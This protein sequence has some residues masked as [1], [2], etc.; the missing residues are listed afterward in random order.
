METYKTVEY[1]DRTFKIEKLKALKAVGLMTKILAFAMPLGIGDIL[2]SKLGTTV[3]TQKPMDDKEFEK[4][5]I[6][7]LS[8]IKEK[9][10]AG[11]IE[12]ITEEGDFTKTEDN[13]DTQ[14]L[15]K[16]LIE[17]IMLNL[18]GFFG[19]KGLSLFI[20]RIQSTRKPDAQM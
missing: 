16:M 8:Q 18:E 1:K 10:G 6:S 17:S 13:Y 15:I 4:L 11:W 19:E 20:E 9:R 5:Q 3:G 14:L 2:A 12:I 7:L